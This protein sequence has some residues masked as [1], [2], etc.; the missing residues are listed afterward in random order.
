MEPHPGWDS[1]SPLVTMF[2]LATSHAPS[3]PVVS[4]PPPLPSHAASPS[5]LS[6]K[7]AAHHSH[8]ASPASSQDK[9]ELELGDENAPLLNVPC[10]NELSRC[11]AV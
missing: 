3:L 5:I 6:S 9:L 11:N 1:L 7:A 10:S 8:H 2:S 4:G